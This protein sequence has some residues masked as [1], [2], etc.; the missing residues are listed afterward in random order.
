[1]TAKLLSRQG[2]GN[3]VW[4]CR[5]LAGALQTGASVPRGLGSAAEEGPPGLQSLLDALRKRVAAGGRMSEELV[6]QG[7]PSHA[8][9]A[10]RYGEAAAALDRALVRLADELDWERAMAAPREGKLHTY[11]LAFARL[12]MMLAAGV[13]AAQALEA[14]AGSVGACEVRDALVAARKAIAAGDALGN[15]L[16][17]A[18]PNLPPMTIEM[19]RDGENDGRLDE[20]KRKTPGQPK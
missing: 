11:S 3:L 19:I 10:V 12:G 6:H 1:M 18:A 7:L 4:L 9:G 14:A 2:I 8:W 5:R 17:R 16:H 15:A 13:P 20:A